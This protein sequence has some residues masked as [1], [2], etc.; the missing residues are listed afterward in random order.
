MNRFLRL[1]AKKLQH[2]LLPVLEDPF[3]IASH[4]KPIDERPAAR[5]VAHVVQ[6]KRAAVALLESVRVMPKGVGAAKLDINEAVRRIPRGD[7]RTPANGKAMDAD[8]VI[9]ESSRP[10]GDGR[11]RQHLEL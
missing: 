1:G 3:H 7:F 5:A 11:G 9:N 2:P 4:E 8:A 10:H 6:A